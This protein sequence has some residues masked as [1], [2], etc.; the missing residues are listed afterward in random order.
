M[1]VIVIAILTIV[2][3]LGSITPLLLTDDVRDIVVQAE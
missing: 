1:L 3:A 2:F